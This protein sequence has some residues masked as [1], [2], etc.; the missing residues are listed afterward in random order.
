MV[1]QVS[2]FV[3]GWGDIKQVGKA[4]PA[5]CILVYDL[6]LTTFAQ[7]RKKNNCFSDGKGLRGLLFK[8]RNEH[9]LFFFCRKP[10]Q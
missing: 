4:M 6:Y 7:N 9:D 8:E 2:T 1:T 5:D 3:S 10:L